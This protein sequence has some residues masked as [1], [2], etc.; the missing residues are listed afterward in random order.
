MDGKKAHLI[1][2]L[3]NL[4]VTEFHPS[5]FI[6]QDLTTLR[7]QSQPVTSSHSLSVLSYQVS[8]VA[9]PFHS[10]D[11]NMEPFS[12]IVWF[13]IS[14]QQAHRVL[15]NVLAGELTIL[16]TV[17]YDLCNIYKQQYTDLTSFK[18]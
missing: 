9:C 10:A 8:L 17:Y 4:S 3:P 16:C 7:Y 14:M 11:R 2:H 15:Q 5:L 18:P 13:L 1:F 6:F 12:Y